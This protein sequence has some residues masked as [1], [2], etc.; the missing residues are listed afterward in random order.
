MSENNLATQPVKD[1][2]TPPP[3]NMENFNEAERW[4]RYTHFFLEYKDDW[5]YPCF[6]IIPLQEETVLAAMKN[7]DFYKLELFSLDLEDMSIRDQWLNKMSWMESAFVHFFKEVF[8]IK[9]FEQGYHY[10]FDLGRIGLPKQKYDEIMAVITKFGL[11]EV[12][13]L[14]FFIIATAQDFYND[15]VRFFESEA[16]AEKIRKVDQQV[17]DAISLIERVIKD[18]FKEFNEK[19]PSDKLL[20]INFIF[21]QKPSIQI[22]D[23]VLTSLIVKDFKEG[24]NN[25]YFKDWKLQLQLFKLVYEEEKIRSQFKFRFAR[26]LYNFLTQT[27]LI[28]LKGKPYPNEVVECVYKIL[29]FSLI[30]VDAK[31]DKESDKIKR[32]RGWIKEHTVT[33][34]I[35]HEKIE[36]DLNKL[37]KY[38]DKDFI[39]C[40][41]AVKGADAIKNGLS[42]CLQFKTQPLQNEIVHIAAC[43]REWNWRVSQQL[44]RGPII[45]NNPMPKEYETFKLFMNSSITNKQFDKITFHV[46]GDKKAHVL[47]EK[48]PIH[49]IQTAVRNHYKHFREDYETDILQ[50]VIKNGDTPGSFSAKTTGK[51]NLPEERFFPKFIDSFF[52]FLQAEAPAL[53]KEYKPSDRYYFLIAKALH[54]TGYFRS[55]FPE[56]WELKGKVEYWHSLINKQEENLQKTGY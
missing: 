46:Q 51:F 15:K 31:S 5:I 3:L 17:E 29:T 54:I 24:F 20:R 21:E 28:K 11:T 23:P 32:V 2:W 52:S 48:L 55:Q 22:T 1:K 41:G 38:F 8:E 45:E 35:T 27:G 49:F 50:A 13:D 25:G 36:P 56:D 14:I 47:T 26:A 44:E 37:Y 53:E 43:L 34:M 10:S 12:S 30:K 19:E 9:S 6:G 39:D 40:V 16:Q 33:P 7:E 18:P 4:W 42:L